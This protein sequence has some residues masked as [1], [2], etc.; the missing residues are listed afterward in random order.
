MWSICWGWH[1][2]KN[3]GLFFSGSEQDGV[4]MNFH[5][6]DPV[7]YLLYL[8]TSSHKL[9]SRELGCRCMPLSFRLL[10][11]LFESHGKQKHQQGSNDSTNIERDSGYH[12]V[13]TFLQR[14]GCSGRVT[15]QSLAH[16]WTWH[17]SST[18]DKFQ[19][20]RSMN[21]TLCVFKIYSRLWVNETLNLISFQG[22]LLLYVRLCWNVTHWFLIEIESVLQ[23]SKPIRL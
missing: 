19:E 10:I 4:T 11:Y 16:L 23:F 21:E 5:V 8:G 22:F 12:K 9:C 2:F 18:S 14:L 7:V 13:C 1:L 17:S 20:V 6:V 3:Q 15:M